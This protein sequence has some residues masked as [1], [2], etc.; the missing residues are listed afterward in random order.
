MRYNGS[1]ES[2]E[3]IHYQYISWPDHGIPDSGEGFLFLIEQA[4]SVQSPI[5][6]HCSAGSIIFI[7]LKFAGVGRTGVFVLVDSAVKELKP[8]LENG[9]DIKVNI[10]RILVHLRECRPYLIQTTAQFLF[11]IDMIREIIKPL[12]KK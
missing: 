10:A 5:T 3:V 8:Q 4:N 7:F 9:E 6:V 1:D 11:A 2:R 12:L